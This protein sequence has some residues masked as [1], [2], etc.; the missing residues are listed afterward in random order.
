MNLSASSFTPS[1]APKIETSSNPFAAEFTSDGDGGFKQNSTEFK[2][3]Q[4]ED[5]PELGEA[6]QGLNIQ[7]TKKQKEAEEQ[8][9]RKKKQQEEND[10]LPTK[11]NPS[12]FFK[13]E[14]DAQGNALLNSEQKKFVYLH[15]VSYSDPEDMVNIIDWLYTQA[16]NQEEWQKQE[17]A[18]Y[19]KA[20]KQAKKQSANDDLILQDEDTS[21]G[22]PKKGFQKKPQPKMTEPPKPRK[23]KVDAEGNEVKEEKKETK[24]NRVKDVDVV[25]NEEEVVEVD[26]TR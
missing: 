24:A 25:V 2:P 13:I 3:E 4:K 14:V 8:A 7:K 26:T 15:Y 22:V 18:M 20:A 19:S 17:K 1:N 23:K 6:T 9:L 12:K 21:F 16:F 10:V 11:G 5:F